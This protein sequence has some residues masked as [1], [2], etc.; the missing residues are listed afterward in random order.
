MYLNETTPFYQKFTYQTKKYF[1]IL[2]GGAVVI[3]ETLKVCFFNSKRAVYI[4]EKLYSW[5]VFRKYRIIY[6]KIK[7]A[8]EAG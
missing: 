4:T 6:G 7:Y 5:N 2:F 8:V 1:T 3:I